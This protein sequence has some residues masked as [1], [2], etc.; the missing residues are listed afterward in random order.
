MLGGR[1]D[2]EALVAAV[3]DSSNTCV[4]DT[5]GALVK[6]T[7]FSID[8]TPAFILG[9]DSRDSRNLLGAGM[10]STSGLLTL[11]T[12][13]PA[14]IDAHLFPPEVQCRRRDSGGIS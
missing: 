9:T 12:H 7:Q 10:L 8:A 6:S 2:L 3:A 5:T 14:G 13:A 4:S 11:L 1:E